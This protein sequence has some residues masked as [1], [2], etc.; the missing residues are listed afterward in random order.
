[1]KEPT[2]ECLVWDRY[3]KAGPASGHSGGRQR[4]WIHLL[5]TGEIYKDASLSPVYTDSLL[6]CRFCN[7]SV[8]PSLANDSLAFQ[9][10]N[11]NNHSYLYYKKRRS[12]LPIGPSQ[13]NCRGDNRLKRLL[14]DNC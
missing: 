11:K 2:D 8:H 9:K 3:Q 14:R 10:S 7:F 1:M 6:E 4:G 5:P 12:P 13:G